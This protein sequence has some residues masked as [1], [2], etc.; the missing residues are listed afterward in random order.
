[1]TDSLTVQPEN[2]PIFGHFYDLPKDVFTPRRR[3]NTNLK[4]VAHF[5]REGGSISPEQVALFTG[6]WWLTL[7]G[8]VALKKR[9]G[10]LSS[11]GTM[12]QILREGGSI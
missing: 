1:L 3:I 8:T 9:N 12:A 6:M 10:W 4:D 11:A 7:T 5:Y 2:L